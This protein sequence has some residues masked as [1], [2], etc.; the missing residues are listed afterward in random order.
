MTRPVYE[1]CI[2]AC[3]EKGACQHPSGCLAREETMNDTI[4]IRAIMVRRVGDDV[5]VEIETVKG[6]PWVEVIRDLADG[7]FSH[8]VEYSGMKKKLWPTEG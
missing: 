5:V 1:R 8:I 4:P 2:P 7:P 6:G 3:E